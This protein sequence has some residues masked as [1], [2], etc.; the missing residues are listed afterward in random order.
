VGDVIASTPATGG[1]ALRNTY[2]VLGYL[3]ALE[4]VIQAA[5][6]AWAT[7]GESKFVDEGGTVDKSLVESNTIPFDGVIG[8]IVHA[9]NGTA[10][11]PCWRSSC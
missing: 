6:I 10:L 5:A 2:R 7:F 1:S 3:I 11:I 8:F 4:V 9:N